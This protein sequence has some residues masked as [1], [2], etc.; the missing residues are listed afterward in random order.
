MARSLGKVAAA[1]FPKPNSHPGAHVVKVN[2]REY[3]RDNPDFS[4]KDNINRDK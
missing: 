1:M 2:E 4:M 3:V